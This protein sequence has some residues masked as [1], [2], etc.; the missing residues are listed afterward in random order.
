M[1]TIALVLAF[2]MFWILPVAAGKEKVTVPPPEKIAEAAQFAKRADSM[3]ARKVFKDAVIEYQKALAI[4]PSDHVMHNKLEIAYH[5]LQNLEMAKKQYERARKIN[6]Q[7]HEDWNNFGN[8]ALQPE[9][10][11]AGCERLQGFHGIEWVI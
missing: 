8:G 4:T 9:E 6:P 3:L 10:T 7:Y 11:Q 5:Q 1:K 2:S